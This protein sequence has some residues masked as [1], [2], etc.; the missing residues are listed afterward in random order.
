MAE[1]DDELSAECRAPV[2]AGT[3]QLRTD[4]LP[5][6]GRNDGRRPKP[7]PM[8][9]RVRSKVHTRESDMT[10]DFAVAFGHQRDEEFSTSLRRPTREAS[11]DVSKAA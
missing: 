4:A 9:S 7:K 11:A 5:L 8:Q 2:K 1:D 3:N 10:D 6:M